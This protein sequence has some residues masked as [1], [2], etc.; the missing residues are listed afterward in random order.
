MLLQLRTVRKS[1]GRLINRSQ[2]STH[3][4]YVWYISHIYYYRSLK[5]LRVFQRLLSAVAYWA[6]VAVECTFLPTLAF[7]FVKL[8]QNNQLVTFEV[9]A[10]VLLNWCQKWFDFIP[11][12]PLNILA[13]I[14]NVFAY[15][16]KELFQVY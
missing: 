2:K 7:P 3:L 12:P 16:D 4:H 11:N 10:S 14:E 9:V 5:L 8:L 13:L 15:H 6:P 1:G